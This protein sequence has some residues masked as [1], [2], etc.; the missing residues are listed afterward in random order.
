MLPPHVVLGKAANYFRRS[1][2]RS[3]RQ[4]RDTLTGSFG[5]VALPWNSG[6]RLQVSAGDIPE[7]A[8]NT[9]R[10]IWPRYFAHEFNLLGSGWVSPAYGFAAPGFLGRRYAPSN[11][12]IID[13]AGAWIEGRV[14]RANVPV[15][16]AIVRKLSDGYRP[17]DWQLD[18][19]SGY[20][21]D[22]SAHS[23]DLPTPI[24]VGADIKIPWELGRLQ[25][26]PQLGLSLIL[27]MAGEDGFAAP[28]DYVREISDQIVDFI[29]LN[30]PRFG[31]NWMCTMDVGIRAANLAI[32][33]AILN[34]AEM[35]LSPDVDYILRS[36][37]YDHALHILDHLEYSESGRSNHYLANIA[38]L[39]WIARSLDGAAELNSWMAF[40]IAE[41]VKE[42]EVQLLPDGG[43]YEGSTNYHR[44][45]GELLVFT[46][47]LICGLDQAYLERIDRATPPRWRA[48]APF[49]ELPLPRYGN[50]RGGTALMPPCIS[51]RLFLAGAFAAAV[52]DRDGR[53]IQIGDTDSGRLFKLQPVESPSL[54]DGG[55]KSDDPL[56]HDGFIAAVGALFG[57]TTPMVD[58]AVVRSLAS[59]KVLARP[60]ALAGHLADVGD[61]QDAI[62]RIMC[63][64]VACRR[65]RL[66]RL[67]SAEQSGE[68][69]R[70]AFPNFGLFIFR[71]S[72]GSHVAFRCAPEPPKD[73]PLGHTHDDNLG[74]DFRLHGEAK[75]DPGT[76][77]YTPSRELRNHYRSAG[78]HD[79]PRA[80]EWS[81]TV[82]GEYLFDICHSG[83]ARCLAWVPDGVAGELVTPN[84]RLYRAIRFR[85]DAIEIWDGVEPPGSLK[86]LPA[87]TT[88]CHGYGNRG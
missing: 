66:L 41:C 47:A 64:P 16:R 45:S 12:V 57:L 46:A 59:Q 40:C 10:A 28:H 17:I 24:D 61:L 78:V 15:A 50:A 56:R 71:H 85:S 22:S 21:W 53:A 73:A 39:I 3:L 81:V 4:Y 49:P 65:Q 68:W 2:E 72:T 79:V 84:G 80:N 70:S 82:A 63:L 27:A 11:P 51:E 58:S 48:R 8:R 13:R 55:V 5:R 33:A 38:G 7:D 88:A 18:F 52:R 54:E 9:L 1:V 30:P 19:R 31:V 76:F 37:L 43:T 62:D 69:I 44:L 60:K 26:L 20:R 14:N 74:V 86:T 75:R 35:P 83:Y 87:P 34:A 36:S 32:T 29:A 6:F 77:V 67:S 23:Y 42:I 25:H